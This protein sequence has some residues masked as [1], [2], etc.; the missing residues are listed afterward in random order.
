MDDFLR[1]QRQNDTPM[2]RTSNPGNQQPGQD[3]SQ[4]RGTHQAGSFGRDRRRTAT[5]GRHTMSGNSSSSNYGGYYQQPSS[6]G[7]FPSGSGAAPNAMGYGQSTAG[8]GQDT[9][10]PPNFGGT[11]NPTTAGVMY[12]VPHAG[13]QSSVFDASQSFSARQPSAMQMLSAGVATASYFPGDPLAT[14]ATAIHAQAA[15]P[16]AYPSV[17]F[18]KITS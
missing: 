1:R 11:Y 7:A 13:Q 17:L 2:R 8:Y 18:T 9:R 6:A 5:D 15:P 12:N 14:A 3:A 10:Q 16:G 4:Q